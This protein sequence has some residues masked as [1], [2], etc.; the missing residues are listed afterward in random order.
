MGNKIDLA[1]ERQITKEEAEKMASAY[2][3]KYFEASA[4]DNIGVKDFILNIVTD[5]I[6]EREKEKDKKDME[7]NNGYIDLDK[8]KNEG[9]KYGFCCL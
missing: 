4:K 5:I 8:Q 2:S 7:G 6:K 1:E 9:Q 3:L